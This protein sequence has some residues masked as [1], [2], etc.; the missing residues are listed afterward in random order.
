[1]PATEKAAEGICAR[2]G[3]QNPRQGSHSYCS[4]CRTETQARYARDRDAMMQAKGWDG[5]AAAMKADLLKSMSKAHPMGMLSVI[6]ICR[7][8]AD[9]PAPKCPAAAPA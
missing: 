6:E 8:V 2:E 4:D 5:G 9:T 3:C 1:M 7:W